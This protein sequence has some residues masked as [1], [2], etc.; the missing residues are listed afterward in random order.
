MNVIDYQNNDIQIKKHKS[1]LFKRDLFLHLK[2]IDNSKGRKRDFNLICLLDYLLLL[3]N[4]WKD[5]I[6]LKINIRKKIQ[7]FVDIDIVKYFCEDF[8]IVDYLWDTCEHYNLNGE[9][10]KNPVKYGEVCCKNHNNMPY[11]KDSLYEGMLLF[12]NKSRYNIGK[13]PVR[14]F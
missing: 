11:K 14:D 2:K 12:V 7:K 6:E 9:V 4:Q 13:P 10:C 8:E 3:K 1:L 5:N